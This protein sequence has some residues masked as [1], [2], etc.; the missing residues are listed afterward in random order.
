MAAKKATTKKAPAEKKPSLDI[1]DEMLYA[2][3]KV[4]DWLDQQ[5]PELAKTFSPLVAMKWMSVVQ[6]YNSDEVGE[7]ILNVNDFLNQGFWELSKHPDLQ[8]R[9]MCATGSGTQQRHGWIPLASS[10]KKVNKV[11]QV[12]LEIHPHLND[13]ELAIM[14]AKFTV[15]SFKQLLLDMAKTD[16]DIKTLVSEFKKTNG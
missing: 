3:Y 11:D 4:F 10:R 14:R 7:A 8:W 5:T 13:E 16:D 6:S 12:L 1:K 15:E 2:D 9:L